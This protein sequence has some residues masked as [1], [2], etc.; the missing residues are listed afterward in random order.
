MAKRP[1]QDSPPRGYDKRHMPSTTPWSQDPNENHQQW[2]GPPPPSSQREDPGRYVAEPS[3]RSRNS[4]N[5]STTATA[6]APKAGSRYKYAM[7]CS[8]NVNRSMEAHVALLN[9]RLRV[10]SYGA[11]R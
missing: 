8:S 4:A 6:S 3:P 2:L 11:G 7:V 10:N 9:Q 5:G 1:R